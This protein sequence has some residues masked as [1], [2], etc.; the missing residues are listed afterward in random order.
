MNALAYM[1][2]HVSDLAIEAAEGNLMA[3]D[4]GY[5]QLQAIDGAEFLGANN[6]G[7]LDDDLFEMFSERYA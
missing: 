6:N 2:F 5:S 3:V 7:R 1:S 4:N